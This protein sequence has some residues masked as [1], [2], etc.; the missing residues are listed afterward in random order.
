MSQRPMEKGEHF[1]CAGHRM[2]PK[3]REQIDYGF[4]LFVFTVRDYFCS[5]VLAISP[6]PLQTPD[7]HL[8]LHVNDVW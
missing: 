7:K 4:C 6:T 3:G 1:A 5:T 2:T 8:Y